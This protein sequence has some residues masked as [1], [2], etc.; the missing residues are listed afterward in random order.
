VQSGSIAQPCRAVQ[1]H[2]TSSGCIRLQVLMPRQVGTKHASL[3]VALLLQQME[4]LPFKAT[5]ERVKLSGLRFSSESL[6][7]FIKEFLSMH[8]HSITNVSLNDIVN[9]PTT[10]EDEAT[11]GALARAF[12]ESELEILNLSSN[13]I[14]AYMWSNWVNQRVLRQLILDRVDMDD[15]SIREL[16]SQLTFADTLDDLHVVLSK[17][18]GMFA[19]SE[20]CDILIKCKGVTSLRWCN[21]SSNTGSKLPWFGLR[22][23]VC[24]PGSVNALQHLVMDGTLITVS[25]LGNDGMSGALQQLRHLR[26]LKLRD[27]GLRDDGV[28]SVIASLQRSQPP[29]EWLDLSGNMIQ[30]EGV[31]AIA[32]IVD[33]GRVVT[34][35]EVL[36]LERNLIDTEGG[37]YLVKALAANMCIDFDI[38][39]DDNPINLSKVAMEM[40]FAEARARKQRAEIRRELHIL[41]DEYEQSLQSFASDRT[42]M[43]ANIQSLEGEIENTKRERDIL[44]RAC[45]LVTKYNAE[46]DEK[47]LSDRVSE[48]EEM[49]VDSVQ[50]RSTNNGIRM[51]PATQ[52]PAVFR[53]EATKPASPCSRVSQTHMMSVERQR[54]LDL[55]MSAGNLHV[56][57]STLLTSPGSISDHRWR[58]CAE[59]ATLTPGMSKKVDFNSP[60]TVIQPITMSQRLTSLDL[61]PAPEASSPKISKTTRRKS[62][63]VV[64]AASPQMSRRINRSSRFY[65]YDRSPAKPRRVA[66]CCF[67]DNEVSNDCDREM[68]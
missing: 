52:Q 33:I 42:A 67:S 9:G 61:T 26:T 10:P 15:V 65:K 25:E 34:N 27:V 50:R 21:L 8:T 45:G 31:K 6:Q 14:G 51:S 23:M 39:L 63:S 41:C 53:A 2:E 55:T 18:A 7:I 20:A 11:F 32:Q 1:K 35:I 16:A 37:V 64:R 49:L 12:H 38:R 43:I 66:S 24:N 4:Q 48:L 59:P 17:P 13:T 30:L 28:R 57:S 5:V 58:G 44:K 36:V 22:Q 19:M 56:N 54:I 62:T 47:R 29:L 68:D 60:I 46:N 40:A 3:V